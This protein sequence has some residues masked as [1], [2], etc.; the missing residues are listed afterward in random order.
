[1]RIKMLPCLIGAELFDASGTPIVEGAPETFTKTAQGL[2]S[3]PQQPLPVGTQY[4]YSVESAFAGDSR[5]YESEQQ[6]GV[7]QNQTARPTISPFGGEIYKSTPVNI[8]TA[9]TTAQAEYALLATG[10]NCNYVDENEWLSVNGGELNL[11]ESTLLCARATHSNASNSGI[12]SLEFS[13]VNEPP[14]ITSTPATSVISVGGTFSY[15]VIAEDPDDSSDSFTYQLVT[16][17]QGMTVSTT[18]LVSWVPVEADIGLH[19]ITVQVSDGVS[20]DKQTFGLTIK[21]S[22]PI[23]VVDIAN[24]NIQNGSFKV[25]WSLNTTVSEFEIVEEFN[26]VWGSPQTVTANTYKDFS[27]KPAGRYRYKVG[28]CT[29]GSCS[30][31]RTSA[32]FTLSAFTPSNAVS[33]PVDLTGLSGDVGFTAGQFRV[34][35]SG[36]A[37]YSVP[38]NLPAGVAGVKPQVALNYSSQGGDGN[39]GR[40]WSLAVGGAISRCPANMFHNGDISG[41]RYDDTDLFCLNSQQLVLK[42]GSYGAANST[43]YT[44]IDGFSII[45]AHGNATDS[46]PNYFTV[47][48]KAGDTYYYGQTTDANDVGDAFVEPNTVNG[49]NAMAKYWALKKLVDVSG[50][51]ILYHYNE[52]AAAGVHALTSLEY[53]KNEGVSASRYF[54]KV[55]FNYID[56][57]K[58]R[59]G[60]SGGSMVVMDQLLNSISITVDGSSYRHY[61]LN[62]TTS[63]IIEERNY[64]DSIEECQ[65]AGSHCLAPLTFTWQRP[66]AITTS[67]TTKDYCEDIVDGA[68]NDICE[69][70]QSATTDNFE[71]FAAKTNLNSN[72]TGYQFSRVIDL[73]ADGYS[74]IVFE[75]DGWRVL[76][77]PG[78][79]N[80]TTA[81]S[82]VG[83]SD[84]D[85]NFILTIDY[86]GDGKQELLVGDTNGDAPNG[87]WHVIA[88][89]NGAATALNLNIEAIGAGE[90]SAAQILDID[91]DGLQ[92]IVFQ[93]SSQ[94][95]MYRNLGGTFAAAV[96][97]RDF[98]PDDIAIAFSY[99]HVFNSPAMK[100]SAI[101][102]VNGDGRSELL[103][104]ISMASWYCEGST[105]KDTQGDC[106]EAGGTWTKVETFSWQVFVNDSTLANPQLSEWDSIYYTGDDLRVTDLNG[107]GLTDVVYYLK[108]DNS[109]YYHLSNGKNF[110]SKHKTPY[111]SDEDSLHE[112]FF[113]DVNSDGR[114]DILKPTGTT[115]WDIL[116]SRPSVGSDMVIWDKR[117]TLARNTSE[118]IKFGDVDGDGKLDLLS[119]SND[120]GWKVRHAARA[121]II[122]NVITD[123]TNGWG[124]STTVTY[125]SMLN[126]VVNIS[127][128]VSNDIAD[129]LAPVSAMT[130]VQKVQSDSKTNA[131]VAVD[132]RYGGLLLHRKGLHWALNN[133][134]PPTHKAAYKL[135]QP[136]LRNIHTLVCR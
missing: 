10:G 83:T 40:G 92:D 72:S 91:G 4:C 88:Y 116:L 129:T 102:D 98:N 52:E 79:S 78:Y 19:S 34:S 90:E 103:S 136:I 37:T 21:E 14:Q 55:T 130:V 48:T 33:D 2:L 9:D 11:E 69:N 22:P 39:M 115:S 81:I 36:A 128:L 77:G 82:M 95:R 74:D 24:L 110:G 50:N 99:D 6:C 7:V 120:N 25:N 8:T 96:T 118:T 59:V 44:A 94:I 68:G 17:P 30:N 27:G 112:I 114:A 126:D 43:Y 42:A 104:K 86:D 135:L 35:E 101:I 117:G 62:Y 16:A 121:G 18:G 53:G 31:H 23:A 93:T 71:P 133:C 29:S 63:P 106:A 56:D 28:S 65:S 45:T 111:T 87:N 26:G 125:N 46:G 124:V 84:L 105:S 12:V 57:P 32:A 109:W 3:A 131:R 60:Y 54:N 5:A 108:A 47:E 20:T 75:D 66:P 61:Q 67:T 70:Y 123:F 15:A 73:N 51:A 38:L 132:Y 89:I 58:P 1:M 41:I 76:Y 80:S 113:I 85:R 64:L 97:L 119:A 49:N 13:V 100:N 134:K 122:D 107:D 127:G